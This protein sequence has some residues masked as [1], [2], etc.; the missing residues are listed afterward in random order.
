MLAIQNA[1]ISED[2]LEKEFVCHLD[3]CKGACCVIGDAGAP[4]AENE[5][6]EI[7]KHLPEIKKH[8]N[9]AGLD[10]LEGIGFWEKDEQGD[11]VTTCLPSGECVF[12]KYDNEGVTSCAIQLAYR[13]GEID[14]EKPISCHLYP[15]RLKESEEFTLVNYHEWSLCK[16]ACSLGT[17]LKVPV[18]RFLEQPL[19]RRFGR[20]WYDELCE[21]ADAYKKR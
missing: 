16:A 17:K 7:E 2:V 19:V 18:Y 3:K 14:F 13:A 9:E 4:L 1:L 11:L 20:E 10:M 5:I 21:V 15:I 6:G 8:M 12:V